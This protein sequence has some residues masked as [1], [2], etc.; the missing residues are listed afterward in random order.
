MTEKTKVSYENV[1]GELR[2]KLYDSEFVLIGLG[3]EWSIAKN[4]EV[5]EDYEALYHLL[6]GKDYF[7]V[8]TVTDGCILGSHLNPD[9]IVAPCGNDH[10]F[11]CS[12]ACTR[13]IWEEGEAENGLC[14]HCKSPLCANTV[15]QAGELYIEEGYLAKWKAYMEWLS[16]TL[17]RRLLILEL[18]EGYHTPTV[19]RWPFEKTAFFNQKAHMFRINEKFAQIAKELSEKATA[20]SANSA[21]FIR[22]L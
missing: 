10:W 2:E 11:Q 21:E 3:N 18:G 6:D 7:I 19:V 1:A 12:E 15:A 22:K 16:K 17:N 9:R 13:D 8:T 14:P 20:F 5:M 4:C